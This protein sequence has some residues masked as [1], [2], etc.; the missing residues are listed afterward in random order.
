MHTNQLNRSCRTLLLA[1]LYKFMPFC[2]AGVRS[3]Q[4]VPVQDLLNHDANG[5]HSA[6]VV[7]LASDKVEGVELVAGVSYAKVR[8][9]ASAGEGVIILGACCLHNVLAMLPL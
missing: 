9:R 1:V 3:V 7:N 5:P 6:P 4:L 2:G 8:A